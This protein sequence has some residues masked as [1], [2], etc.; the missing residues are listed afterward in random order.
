MGM[1][2]LTVEN[3]EE[4]EPCLSLG[5]FSQ[6]HQ[7]RSAEMSHAVIVLKVCLKKLW[8]N[9][10]HSKRKTVALFQNVLNF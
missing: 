8:K 3:R 7:L 9:T 6:K 2:L 4:E 5:N 10:K 1:K